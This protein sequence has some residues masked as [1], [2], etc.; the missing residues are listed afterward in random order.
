METPDL[1]LFICALT[2]I[3]VGVLLRLLTWRSR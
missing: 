3:P 1:M 2:A